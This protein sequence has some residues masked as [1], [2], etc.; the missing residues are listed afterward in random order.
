[1]SKNPSYFEALM[2]GAN[3]GKDIEECLKGASEAGLGAPAIKNI[4]RIGQERL[5]ELKVK[6]IFSGNWHKQHKVNGAQ[7]YQ[8]AI[9]A[10]ENFDRLELVPDPMGKITGTSHKDPDAIALFVAGSDMLVG[11]ISAK[12]KEFGGREGGLARW[13]SNRLRDNEKWAVYVV[14]KVGQGKKSLGLRI[15]IV[16]LEGP[17]ITDWPEDVKIEAD[18]ISEPEPLNIGEMD[19]K[20]ERIFKLR[21][22]LGNEPREKLRKIRAFRVRYGTY[23]ENYLDWLDS[24]IKNLESIMEM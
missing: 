13:L 9:A 20:L 14:A 10:C 1:M 19:I 8:Q 21:D 2:R 15:N 17:V 11:Y 3:T 24:Q 16:Q 7:Q 12:P 22:M 4:K 5:K 23:S 18:P 6:Q